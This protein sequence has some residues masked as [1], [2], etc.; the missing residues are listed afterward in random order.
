MS[1]NREENTV[2]L[3]LA[4][5]EAESAHAVLENALENGGGDEALELAYRRLGW[6]LL[7]AKRGSGLTARL[8]E[9]ARNAETLEQFER[10][11]DEELGPILGGLESGDNRDP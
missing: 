7:A 11:R 6:R 4:L 10:E 2:E 3:S 9:I 5:G 1:E 8:A